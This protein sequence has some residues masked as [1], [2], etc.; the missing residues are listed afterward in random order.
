V[1]DRVKFEG[2]SFRVASKIGLMPLMRFAH[3][4]KSGV[5][6]NEMAGLA[7]M[8]DLLEQVISDEDWER[9]QDH[10]IA[11]RAGGD[12]L[13][14]VIPAAIEVISSRP[15]RQPSDSSDG[16]ATTSTNSGAAS[17]SPVIARLELAS[18]PDLALM[19]SQA[20]ASRRSA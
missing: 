6:S 9:F 8:Y 3:I 13:M 16:L 12:E 7:A 10:A 19:V 1:S 5:D 14:A 4:A 18:R 15:T 20:E 17:S 11:T 2:E